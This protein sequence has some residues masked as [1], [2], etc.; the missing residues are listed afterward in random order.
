MKVVRHNNIAKD[1]ELHLVFIEF[2]IVN[3]YQAKFTAFEYWLP[4][5][6]PGGNEVTLIG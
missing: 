4:I 5:E 1:F 2:Q 6:H 3:E